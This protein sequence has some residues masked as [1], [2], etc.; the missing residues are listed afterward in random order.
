MNPV[1]D[2]LLSLVFYRF[3]LKG[4]ERC[5]QTS[6]FNLKFLVV[7]SWLA[8]LFFAKTRLMIFVKNEFTG[9]WFEQRTGQTVAPSFA[10]RLDLTLSQIKTKETELVLQQLSDEALAALFT[11]KI[12]EEQEQDDS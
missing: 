6:K 12:K 9:V 2:F 10:E 4:Y 11:K 1:L 7:P 3:Y 5:E 8:R